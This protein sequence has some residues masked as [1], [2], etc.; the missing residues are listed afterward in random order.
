MT[1]NGKCITGTIRLQNRPSTLGKII[2]IRWH[3]RASTRNC[4]VA[5]GGPVSDVRT[6]YSGTRVAPVAHIYYGIS[7]TA[8]LRIHTRQ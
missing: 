1:L 8:R 5:P 2:T 4:L 6:S 7:P 3:A